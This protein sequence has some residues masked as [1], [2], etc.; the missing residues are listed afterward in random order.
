MA[1]RLVAA[2]P[3]EPGEGG[4]KLAVGSHN[5]RSIAYTLALLEKHDLPPSAIEVQNLYGM[6]DPLRAA[7]GQRG[8]RV[9]YYVPLG[10]M[11]PGMA[12]LVRRLLENTS[13][14]SWLRAGFFEEQSPD[15]AVGI[16][17]RVKTSRPLEDRTGPTALTPTLS[18]RERDDA[19]AAHHHACA[20]RGRTGRRVA[21]DE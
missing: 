20:G 13:N 8:V 4:V 12:Y 2:T 3:R 15:D 7:L 9:R 10:E 1:E 16:A 21:D 17:A 5:V 11:I 14:Q 6:A 18:R 19:A